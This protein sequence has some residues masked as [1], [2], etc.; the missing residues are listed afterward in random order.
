ML[1][2]ANHWPSTR[3]CGPRR[4]SGTPTAKSAR[5]IERVSGRE[6]QLGGGAAGRTS[7]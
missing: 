5:A 2:E 4:C 6:L 1:A 3:S 7:A